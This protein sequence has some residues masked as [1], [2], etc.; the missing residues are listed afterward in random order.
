LK[1]PSLRCHLARDWKSRSSRTKSVQNGLKTVWRILERWFAFISLLILTG[2]IAL[3]ISACYGVA[4]DHAAKGALSSSPPAANCQVISHLAGKTQVCDSPQRVITL[5]PYVLEPLL[6]LGDQPIGFADQKHSHRGDYDD[7]SQQIPYLSD[8]ITGQLANVGLAYTPSIEAILKLQPD[9]ILGTEANLSQYETLS[10]IAPT[11]LL[12]WSDAQINLRTIAQV[13]QQPEKASQLLLKAKQQIE[14]ARKDFS[15]LVAERPRISLL[16]SDGAQFYLINAADNL[17]SSLISNLGFQLVYPPGL[18]GSQL[19]DAIPVSSESL[20][21][22]NDAHSIILLGSPS[23][24]RK[25][26]GSNHEAEEPSLRSLEQ[27]WRKNA[28]AQALQASQAGQV[29]FMPDYVC[30]G[31]PGTIGT[32]LYLN[33]LRKQLLSSSMPS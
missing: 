31:L 17:C 19:S 15:P 21:Q 27:S 1:V 8:R 28:I 30:L 10:K 13:V 14:I 5:G 25:L 3:G 2:L 18:D 26:M 7:P 6:A 23:S 32:E 29:Y 33:E 22:L 4:D 20:G 12:K 11:L 16:T 24:E 9:L